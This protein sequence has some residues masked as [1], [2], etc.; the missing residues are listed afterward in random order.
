MLPEDE[1]TK[2]LIR[3]YTERLQILKE[4]QA[5]EGRTVD[6][7]IL[8]EIEEIEEK[9]EEL[10]SKLRKAETPS[11]PPPPPELKSRE[12]PEL[13]IRNIFAIPEEN[14][15]RDERMKE[16]LRISSQ[17]LKLLARTGYNY[18][19]DQGKNFQAGFGKH[20]EEGENIKVLLENP[21]SQFAQARFRAGRAKKPMS[22]LSAGRI[23]EVLDQYP[24]LEIRFTDNPVYCSLF[25][26]STS[27][28]Y[29]P[30]HLGT[31]DR[32]TQQPGNQFLVF[33]FRIR[34]PRDLYEDRDYY[35]L[36]MSHFRFLWND[37]TKTFP[38]LCN[39]YPQHLAACRKRHFERA[40]SRSSGQHATW[41]SRNRR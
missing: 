10:E 1:F 13:F 7:K 3:I 40:K 22:K 32:R 16:L 21:Y 39:E 9:I 12:I 26:T 27:V 38:Q 14:S 41:L 36:L 5:I 30:Y 8:I 19:H 18:L 35:S 24:N 23:W 33:E 28:I 4:Q 17:D 34:R 11:P 25:F 20:L 37:R 6:P 15:Q 29:D 2:K 31:R